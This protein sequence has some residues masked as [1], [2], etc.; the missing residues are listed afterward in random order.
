MRSA[1][2][3]EGPPRAGAAANFLGFSGGD[4][5]PGLLR[6]GVE[7]LRMRTAPARRAAFRP[8]AAAAALALAALPG[9]AAAA[10]KTFSSGSL[11]IPASIEYQSDFGILGTYGLAYILL[12]KNADRVANGLKPVTLYWAVNPK[13]LSQYHCDTSTNA[14]PTYTGPNDNDGCD[15]AVQRAAA[16][17]GQPVTRLAPDFTEQSS[18]AVSNVAYA[19]STGP[20]RDTTTHVIDATTTVVKYLGGV[21]IVDATDRDA[22][23]SMMKGYTELLQFHKNGPNGNSS[24]SPPNQADTGQAGTYVNIHSAKASFEAA[25]V[26]AL[27]MKPNRIAIIGSN[28]TDFLGDV[29]VN[30]GICG[31]TAANG[32][33]NCG[34]TYAAGFTSGVV[35]DYYPNTPDV[36]DPVSG[37]PNGRLNGNVN[38]DTYAIL[39]A[40]DG[41]NPTAAEMAS[42]SWFLNARNTFFAEYDSPSNVEA[43]PTKYM[44]TAGI[45][46]NNPN[47]AVYEDCNDD[48][49]PVGSKFK[50]D[51]TGKNNGCLVYGGA[52][53]PFAQTGNF[54]FQGGQ[55]SYKG[56]RLNAGSSWRPGVTQILQTYDGISVALSMNKDNVPSR[57]LVMYLGG[58]K[59]DTGGRFWGQRVILNSV[60][61]KL[62]PLPPTELA[63]SEPIAYS[64]TSGGTTT[65][66]VFQG[67]Y[68][69]QPQPDTDDVR[70]Y[71]PAD[72]LVWQ[73][74]F[75]NGHLYAY[76]LDSGTTLSSTAQAFAANSLWD[77][78]A[79]LPSPASRRIFTYSG[80]WGKLGWK[81]LAFVAAQTQSG[82]T[83]ADGDGYCDLS[84]LLAG[85]NTAGVTTSTLQ[86]S[87][88]ADQTQAKMLAQFVQQVRGFCA[89]HVG[90]LPT[91]APLLDESAGRVCDDPS[92]GN[93]AKL[94]GIDHSSPA[95]VGPSPYRK[96][97]PYGTRPVVAYAAGWDGM[98][99]AFWVSGDTAWT[100]DGQSV[101]AGTVAGTEL[102]A[103]I[104]PGQVGQLAFNHAVVDGSVN[105][106]DAF[107]DFPVDAN[108]DGVIDWSDPNE[109]PTHVRSWRTV[110]LAT[111]G[112]GGSEAFALDVT[113]PLK[114]VL[115]WHVGGATETNNRYD[116]NAN[117][118]LDAG[119][120]RFSALVPSSYSLKWFDWDDGDDTTTWI[121]TDYNT[122]DATVISHLRTG[123]YNYRNMGL[124]YRTAVAKLWAGA[125]YQYVAFLATSAADYS[126]GTPTGFRGVEVFA[127]DVV[128]GEKLWQWEHLYATADGSGIDNSIPPG[129]ALGD[130]D[131][132][133]S[134]DRIYVADLEGR[135]W[136]LSAKDGR[137]I[138]Y[139][140]S[141]QTVAGKSV[142]YS[143]PLFGSGR[144]TGGVDPNPAN[145]ADPGTLDLYRTGPDSSYPLSQQPLTT[146]IGEGRFTAVP[147]ASTTFDPAKL[148]GRLALILGTMGVDWSIAPYENGHIYVVPAYPDQG[149]RLSPPIAVGSGV[150]RDPLS[151]GILDPKAI[152]DIQLNVGERVYG[153]PK[154]ANNTIVFNTAF[155][156]FG[157]D[158]TAS[159]LA[160][161]NLRVV[162][163]T[164]STATAN[165]AKAFGGTLVV[166]ST[167]VVTTDEKIRKVTGTG[168]SAGGPTTSPFNRATPA[169]MKTWEQVYQ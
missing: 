32:I 149:T 111:A 44:T 4:G 122:S 68:M 40:G 17:G 114:P 158:I 143:F 95:V 10:K 6:S 78:A 55:G 99:H 36:L 133:G 104:P 51:G 89:S 73:F 66:K 106:V 142:Y 75:T 65:T 86:A 137:N 141:N 18:F 57:G 154:V 74:P 96:G 60:F 166:G 21:W 168:V 41:G 112:L 129:V 90:Q 3:S 34:A 47:V 162:T 113:N 59:F 45:D 148:V 121:P 83:D 119:D 76:N 38:G 92:Q 140:A 120:T 43:T 80:G 62:N 84:E 138:N 117:G 2:R 167:V 165:D 61:T 58:H 164:S 11:I 93:V 145:N 132:N 64:T 81:K 19:S 157:G 97:A 136:E 77:A 109:L 107:G 1:V 156:S 134:V 87:N 102:W 52:N 50:G 91:G 153:M 42:I 126:T 125:S 39:W 100:A 130:I 7:V 31:A 35:Y 71:N 161:G 24:N 124:C 128:S 20:T 101:P 33:V 5:A 147:G 30:A 88:A 15:F 123:R 150:T 28:Q 14:L 135:L 27:T 48:L 23:I 98:L 160:P 9:P 82:C 49:L 110:L 29:L 115:L 13:K 105:V 155:G 37:Y 118:V 26:S 72:A 69:Q 85:G 53:Q 159:Y 103:M 131:V 70:T 169:L 16:A 12:W 139:L 79:Q 146:P 46:A 144:M 8:I 54:L 116:S 108:G 22:F 163:A 67:T 151:F 25:V 94:G 127:I 152:W 63:R 56:Y